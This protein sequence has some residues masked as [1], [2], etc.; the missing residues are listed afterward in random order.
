MTIVKIPINEMS[1]LTRLALSNTLSKREF[2]IP[3]IPNSHPTADAIGPAIVFIFDNGIRKEIIND[4]SRGNGFPDGGFKSIFD[5]KDV[6]FCLSSSG[7]SELGTDNYMTLADVLELQESGIEW[8]AHVRA[9]DNIDFNDAEADAVVKAQKESMNELGIYP[10]NCNYLQGIN[11]IAYRSIIRKHYRSAATVNPGDSMNVNK[12]PI[13]QYRLVRNSMDSGDYN[14]WTARVDEAITNNALCIFYGHPYTDE[15]YTTKKDDDGIENEAGDYTWQKISRLIDYI[16]A[17]SG[18][19]TDGGINIMTINDAINLHGNIIDVGYSNDTRASVLAGSLQSNDIARESFRVSRRGEVGSRKLDALIVDGNSVALGYTA[20]WL[21]VGI[22][23]AF[24]GFEAG[25]KNT[26]AGCSAIGYR[27]G[28]NNTG[29][30]CL[31]IGSNAGEGNTGTNLVALGPGAGT[32]NTQP[33]VVVVGFQAGATNTGSEVVA[34]GYQAG[35]NNNQRGLASVGYRAAYNNTGIYTT[36][37]GY[38]AA[39][40][41]SGARLTALGFEAGRGNSAANVVAIGDQAGENNTETGVLLIEH[42]TVTASNP[43]IKGYFATGAII[44]GAPAVATGD[45]TM[46]ANRISFWLDEASNKLMFK[47]KYADGTTI[48]SGEVAL[49]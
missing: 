27:A 28:K 24:L 11:S 23:C 38:Y 16:Q 12:R 20:G 1:D 5:S 3:P 40:D 22:N 34:I 32:N 47:V 42:R 43:L 41:N 15:W 39:R 46:G 9:S 6:K 35:I 36:G 37:M 49:I 45:A 13:N 26:G 17:K 30:T 18:Y 10:L 2:L 8:M 29:A 21:N 31:F 33:S 48:K 14:G 7:Y 25:Q 19:G 4:N 44:L